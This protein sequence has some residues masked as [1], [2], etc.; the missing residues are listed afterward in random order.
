MSEEK[1]RSSTYLDSTTNSKYKNT[2]FS[3]GAAA[4]SV[5]SVHQLRGERRAPNVYEVGG[6]ALRRNRV[7]RERPLPLLHL[8][9][10]GGSHGTNKIKM[11]CTFVE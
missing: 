7:E 4:V 3:V 2:L 9:T 8:L 1:G 6:A 5:V 11:M 10:V